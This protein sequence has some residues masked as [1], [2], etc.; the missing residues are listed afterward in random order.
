MPS[1][2]L[3][4]CEGIQWKPVD[5]PHRGPVMRNPDVFFDRVDQLLSKVYASVIDSIKHLI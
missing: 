4:L 3:T 1:A 5:F 2:L